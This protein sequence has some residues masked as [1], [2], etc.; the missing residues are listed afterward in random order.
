[1][2]TAENSIAENKTNGKEFLEHYKN[3][4]NKEK[5]AEAVEILKSY[6]YN[7]YDIPSGLKLHVS[8]TRFS[9]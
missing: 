2:N 3:K 4:W 5:S 8:L 7:S 6:C 9:N 1:M